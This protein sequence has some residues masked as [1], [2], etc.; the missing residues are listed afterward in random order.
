[1]KTNDRAVMEG[2]LMLEKGACDLYMHGAIESSDERVLSSFSS[3]LH[4]S[5]Q[6]QN[7]IYMAMKERGWYE[8]TNAPRDSIVSLKRKFSEN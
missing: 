5:L 7:Q 6:M 8:P 4:Q 1:M 3:A 2:L